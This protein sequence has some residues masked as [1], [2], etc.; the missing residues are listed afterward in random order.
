MLSL[1]K[2]SGVVNCN[3]LLGTREIYSPRR[4]FFLDQFFFLF[5]QFYLVVVCTTIF[6]KFFINKL[7][8]KRKRQV[9]FNKGFY[10]QV[11]FLRVQEKVWYVFFDKVLLFS[12]KII[13]RANENRSRGSNECERKRVGVG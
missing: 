13:E 12:Q 2:V 7:S 9:F 8:K 6:G 5:D 4:R 11:L 1:P 10:C 3:S